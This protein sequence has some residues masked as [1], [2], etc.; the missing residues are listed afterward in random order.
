MPR[1]R[2]EIPK[3]ED[4]NLC[5]WITIIAPQTIHEPPATESDPWPWLDILH[6]LRAREACEG[7][8]GC[9]WTRVLEEQSQI[10]IWTCGWPWGKV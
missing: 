7:F 8:Q 2:P 10:W 1:A 6:A 4:K 5:E 3:E 9:Q